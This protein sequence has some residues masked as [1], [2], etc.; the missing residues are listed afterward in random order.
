[1]K[2]LDREGSGMDCKPR[3][4]ISLNRAKPISAE[5]VPAF[6]APAYYALPLAA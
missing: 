5:K 2:G 3:R 4:L 6:N 1:M